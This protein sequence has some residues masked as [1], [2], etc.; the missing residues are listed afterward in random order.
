MV[1]Q[2]LADA[3]TALGH[4]ER[5]QEDLGPVERGDADHLAGLE[6]HIDFLVAG[7]VEK[8][9]LAMPVRR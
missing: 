4:I 8:I 3:A 9:G 7:G 6:R 5:M 2:D 1:Q